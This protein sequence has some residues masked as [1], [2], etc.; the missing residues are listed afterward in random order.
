M[1]VLVT[2]T[3]KLTLFFNIN[4]KSIMKKF[5]S[6][7]MIAAAALSFAACSETP[8]EPN[9]G[10]GT[11]NG[12]K[13][14]TPVVTAETG[15]TWFT[16]SWGA[17]EG[18]D[19]YTIN[20]KGKNYTTTELSYT[21]ENLNKG[22]YRVNVKAIGEGYKD[23]DFGSV[24]VTLTGATSVKWFTQ[25]V[26][27]GTEGVSVEF[28]WKGEGVKSLT[29]GLFPTEQIAAVDDKTIIANLSTLGKD[30]ATILADVNSEEGFEGVFS[31][32][33]LG[34]T[35]Y[36]MFAYVTNADGIEFLARNEVVTPEAVVAEETKAWLGSW[37]ASTEQ[38]VEYDLEKND[39]SWKI[40]NEKH[41][42]NLSI[43]VDPGTTND[44][45]IYGLSFLGAEYPAFGSV[46]YDA[47][48]KLNL[49]YIWSYQF[50]AKMEEGYAGW[51]TICSISGEYGIV[52]G[53]F[54][55]YIL[56]QN[57][58]GN[59]SCE[60]YTGELSDGGTFTTVGTELFQVNPDTG[61]LGFLGLD[62]KGTPNSR[63]K[64]GALKNLTKASATA[65]AQ[66]AAA[67]TFHS[68][69]IELP[70]SVVVM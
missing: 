5:F 37:T 20:V 36:T 48:N 6:M 54:P 31:Q 35:N 7:M 13:L 62:E 53:N 66:S 21:F 34:D 33:L 55:T 70:A 63:I 9:V 32:N 65:S 39:G 15:D 12:S 42:V 3:T 17:V 27:A 22:E 47:E 45:I 43:E 14:E 25:T 51:I 69:G 67:L 52:T 8:D 18:A 50:I 29:Y 57:A 19:S 60:M 59:V 26:A 2:M 23:S 61:G 44:V 41:D 56:T 11:G 58:Q 30:E 49:L 64:A 28:T 4:Q 38:I 40:S 24:I 46:A 68:T 16:I 10:G 1:I